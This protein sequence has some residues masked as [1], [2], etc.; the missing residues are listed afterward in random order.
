M[1][2]GERPEHED[3][4]SEVVPLVGQGGAPS[5]ASPAGSP[6]RSGTHCWRHATPV[7]PRPSV[8]DGGDRRRVQGDVVCGAAGVTDDGHVVALLAGHGPP[9]AEIADSLSSRSSAGLRPA[10]A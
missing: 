3:A 10:V 4:R 9:R 7:T 5:T 6:L 1:A 2:T 8:L